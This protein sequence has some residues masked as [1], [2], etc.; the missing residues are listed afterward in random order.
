MKPAP[1][2]VKFYQSG[3]KIEKVNTDLMIS[4][5]I[6][7]RKGKMI[8]SDI[9]ISQSKFNDNDSNIFEGFS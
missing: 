3:C 4:E 5:W 9:S 7:S 2:S 1:D 6:E 8:F